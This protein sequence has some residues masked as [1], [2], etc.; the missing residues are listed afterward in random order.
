MYMT[1]LLKILS[2]DSVSWCTDFKLVIL[3]LGFVAGVDL[4]MIIFALCAG[5]KDK[6]GNKKD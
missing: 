6:H 4:S 5:G 3:I 2:P 1:L